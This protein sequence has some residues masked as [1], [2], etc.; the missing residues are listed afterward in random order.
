METFVSRLKDEK[1]QLDE[2]I[3]KLGSFIQS[4]PFKNIDAR[5]QELL[6]CQYFIMQSYTDVLERRI[7]LLMSNS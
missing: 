5:Q 2:K 7:E 1:S 4:D 6:R 3:G